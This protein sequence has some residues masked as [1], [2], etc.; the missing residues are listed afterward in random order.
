[1]SYVENSYIGTPFGIAPAEIFE[2]DVKPSRKEIG[3]KFAYIDGPYTK[4]EAVIKVKSMCRSVKFTL[5]KHEDFILRT[6]EV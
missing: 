6:L 4:V 1:M 3:T 2:S 5:T